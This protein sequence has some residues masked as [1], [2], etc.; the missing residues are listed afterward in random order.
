MDLLRAGRE[1][2]RL[3]AA[4]GYAS[5]FLLDCVLILVRGG[6]RKRG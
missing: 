2:S 4:I 1:T 5:T 3:S 6:D